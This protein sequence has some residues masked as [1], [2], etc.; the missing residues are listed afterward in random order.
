MPGG[1]PYILYHPVVAVLESV[2]DCLHI[3]FQSVVE[4]QMSREM[5]A[6]PCQ[7]RPMEIPKLV[8]RIYQRM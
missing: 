1:V 5:R 7:E 4:L 2:S 3:S 8:L 6:L